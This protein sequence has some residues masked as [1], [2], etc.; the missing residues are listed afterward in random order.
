MSAKLPQSPEVTTPERRSSDFDTLTGLPTLG[1]FNERVDRLIEKF[2]GEFSILYVDLDGLKEANDSGGHAAGN[3]LLTSAAKT[4]QDKIRGEDESGREPDILFRGETYRIG[5]DEF[6]IL[7]A[8]AKTSADVTAVKQRLQTHL[9]EAGIN[10]SMDGR[11]HQADESREELLEA[12]DH[13]MYKD[14]MIRKDALYKE[15]LKQASW[16]KRVA[17]HLGNKLTNYSDIKKPVIR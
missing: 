4:L 5:G 8:G 12:T 10:A 1:L 17:H 7:L 14:K 16:R 2:P 3:E 6:V 11:P 13:M 9:K 15:S